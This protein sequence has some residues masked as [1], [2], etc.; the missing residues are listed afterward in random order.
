M[1]K[2]LTIALF[3]LLFNGL[4]AQSN[5]FDLAPAGIM[6]T[7][8]TNYSGGAIGRNFSALTS[9]GVGQSLTVDIGTS[10]PVYTITFGSW[11]AQD[12]RYIPVGYVID[13]SNDAISWTT[14]ITVTN[15]GSLNPVHTINQTAR[16]WRLTVTAVQ[17]GQTYASISGFALISTGLGGAIGT[18]LW[19]TRWVG[20]NIFTNSSVSIG[21]T[22]P[23]NYK[24]AVNGTIHSKAVIIDLVGWPDYVFKKDYQLMP[25][26]QVKSFI[27]QNQHLPGLPTDKEVEAKGLDVGEMNKLLTKK[28]EELT[29]YLIDLKTEKDKENKEQE[30]KTKAQEAKLTDQQKQIDQLSAQLHLLLI[31]QQNSKTPNP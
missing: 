25:L 21:A 18:N 11:F 13:H 31:H 19:N 17:S 27:D 1:K 2:T 16:Y 6:T 28:V 9:L 14:D 23:G 4:K 8:G 5:F 7:T 15:N 26:A 22:D 20:E 29:L 12:W 10:L 30:A 24:L 3:C